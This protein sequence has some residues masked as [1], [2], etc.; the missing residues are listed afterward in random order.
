MTVKIALS[1]IAAAVALMAG[2]AFAQTTPK[3]DRAAVKAEAAAAN[4]KGELKA[5]ESAPAAPK[6]DMKSDKKR[7]DV[8]ADA[9]AAEKKGEIK[10][11]ESAPVATKTEMKSDKARADVKAETKAAVKKGET[12]KA[13]EATPK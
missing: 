3:E 11:G 6:S 13:G 5:G 8:K 4:K 7:A 10:A 9:A 1:L 12:P 2:Q